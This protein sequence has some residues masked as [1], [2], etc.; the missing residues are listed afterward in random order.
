[1]F[2]RKRN[3]KYLVTLITKDKVED[4]YVTGKS[5][6]EVKKLVSGVLLNCSLFKFKTE[7]DFKLKCKRVYEEEIR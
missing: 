7:K 5:K 3:K 1:M 6:K 2:R 4:M